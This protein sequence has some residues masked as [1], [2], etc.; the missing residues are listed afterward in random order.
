M[1]E[2]TF[3]NYYLWNYVI[4]KDQKPP[5]LSPTYTNGHLYHSNFFVE[6]LTITILLY[7]KLSENGLAF[8]FLSVKWRI[9]GC[10]SY[11]IEFIRPNGNLIRQSEY[12]LFQKKKCNPVLI[13]SIGVKVFGI[14]GGGYA[15]NFKCVSRVK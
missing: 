7:N 12:W 2:S 1:R 13:I 5:L 8:T 9:Q 11:K 15:K 14:P 4:I 6:W 10:T 3:Y